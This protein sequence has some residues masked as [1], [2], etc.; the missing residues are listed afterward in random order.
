MVTNVDQTVVRPVQ[1]D[2]GPPRQRHFTGCLTPRHT[3]AQAAP[4][5]QAHVESWHIEQLVESGTADL[6]LIAAGQHGVGV[7]HSDAG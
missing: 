7:A 1:M 2:D 6:A 5:A 3:Q 4:T